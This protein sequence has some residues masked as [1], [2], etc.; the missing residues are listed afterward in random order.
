M[1]DAF[2]ELIREYVEES[3]RGLLIGAPAT[4][5]KF[6]GK[7]MTCD[8]APMLKDANAKNYPVIP[9]VPV[10][11]SHAGGFFI[12]PEYRQG[13]LV[14]LTF[15][16]FPMANALKGGRDATDG[17][18]FSPENSVV[19]GSLLSTGSAPAEYSKSGLLIGG[20]GVYMQFSDEEIKIKAGNSEYRFTKNGL[21][22]SG[23]IESEGDILADS[24]ARKVSLSGHSH[25]ETGGETLPPG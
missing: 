19:I 20:G 25:K 24:K 21:I 16:T 10:L 12:R 5:Q 22:S 6:D 11:H 14:F 23:K 3:L 1:I 9:D 7:R 17:R 8:V 4:V 18:I 15:S 2:S 13:D